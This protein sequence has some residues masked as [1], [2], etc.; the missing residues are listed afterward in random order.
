MTQILDHLLK[1]MDEHLTG[2]TDS[3]LYRTRDDW[4]DLGEDSERAWCSEECAG[5]EGELF[6]VKNLVSQISC[7][8]VKN[9]LYSFRS[10]NKYPPLK[11][12]DDSQLEKLFEDWID[13]LRY[14]WVSPFGVG[15]DEDWYYEFIDFNG[16][17]YVFTYNYM[18]S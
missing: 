11:E 5:I 3:R 8:N 17:R 16:Q 14:N 12:M 18:G 7:S 6:P 9:S 2:D 13:H 4:D 15:S 10:K 1:L